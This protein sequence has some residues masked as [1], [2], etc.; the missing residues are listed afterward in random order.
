V[1][2]TP[3]P[4]IELTSIDGKTYTL[5]EWVML[6]NIVVTAIDPYTYESS[7]ILKT[8]DRIMHHYDEANARVGF[9]VTSDAEGARQF[10]GPM[11]DDF[12][13]FVDP[14]REFVKACELERLPALLHLRQSGELAGSAEG[15][16]PEEWTKAL[17]VVEEDLAWRSQPQLPAQ[18]TRPPSAAPRPSADGPA[19]AWPQPQPPY[20]QST[21]ETVTWST[22]RTPRSSRSARTP[23]RTGC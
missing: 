17:M 12:L 20:R 21:Q 4:D 13:V 6:F 22:L 5:Q 19:P 10:L 8:A 15:W 9:L 16:D 18:A 14:E 2:T 1:A 23:P 3:P 11:V 7:W